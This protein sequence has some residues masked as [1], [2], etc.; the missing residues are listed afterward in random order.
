MPQSRTNEKYSQVDDAEDEKRTLAKAKHK[1]RQRAEAG[2]GVG[3]S[4]GVCPES[5][6]EGEGSLSGL[7][8]SCRV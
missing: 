8:I 3:Q 1:A 5:E 2:E 4:G 7:L 6:V